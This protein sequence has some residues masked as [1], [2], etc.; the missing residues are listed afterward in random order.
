M[1][2][3]IRILLWTASDLRRPRQDRRGAVRLRRQPKRRRAGLH[4]RTR[5]TWLPAHLTYPLL[6]NCAAAIRTGSSSYSS[7]SAANNEPPTSSLSRHDRPSCTDRNGI[8]GRRLSGNLRCSACAPSMDRKHVPAGLRRRPALHRS[9]APSRA[10]SHHARRISPRRANR[11]SSRLGSRRRLTAA[12]TP[13]TERIRN[14]ASRP[15]NV[16]SP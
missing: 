11:R 8:R 16:A 1:C 13:T 4:R 6:R 10:T 2:T 15:P 7:A 5:A 12:V 3:P 14:R 9:T